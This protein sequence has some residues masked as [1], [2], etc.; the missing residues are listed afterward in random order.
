MLTLHASQLDQVNGEASAESHAHVGHRRVAIKIRLAVLVAVAALVLTGCR[1][2]VVDY[3]VDGDTVDV[4]GVRVR[5]VGST[6]LS[7]GSAGTRRP[8]TGSFSSC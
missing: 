1:S 4:N 6:R 8:R 7:V 5:I 2:G 3:V